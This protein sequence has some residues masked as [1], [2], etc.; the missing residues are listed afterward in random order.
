MFRPINTIKNTK[1]K[2]FFIEKVNLFVKL[3]NAF[4]NKN[5]LIDSSV[6]SELTIDTKKRLKSLKIIESNSAEEQKK[7]F[8][9]LKSPLYQDLIFATNFN[10]KYQKAIGDLLNKL[11]PSKRNDRK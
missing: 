6:T 8:K 5:N 7:L 3:I 11:D 9:T 10:I 4:A 2:K 1:E